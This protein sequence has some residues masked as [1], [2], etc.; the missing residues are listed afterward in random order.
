[1]ARDILVLAG[2]ARRDSVNRRLAADAARA[3]MATRLAAPLDDLV[4]MRQR[5]A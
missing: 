3:A 2:S 5:L 4:A 1:M